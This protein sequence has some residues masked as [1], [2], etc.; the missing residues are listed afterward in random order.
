MLCM[1]ELLDEFLEAAR[2]RFG[3]AVLIHLVGPDG[4]QAHSA[5]LEAAA[6]PLSTCCLAKALPRQ[7]CKSANLPA[8][9][10]QELY[11]RSAAC[12]CLSPAG[13]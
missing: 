11:W 9:D 13:I 6:G 5:V 2:L 8:A 12:W 10:S 7:P 3:N 4:L 1:Q